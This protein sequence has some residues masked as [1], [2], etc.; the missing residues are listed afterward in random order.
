M[1]DSKEILTEEEIQKR[2][3]RKRHWLSQTNLVLKIPDVIGKEYFHY[4]HEKRLLETDIEIL[5][6]MLNHERSR[7]DSCS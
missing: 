1:E 5:E 2:L 4:L 7:E 3:Q 6:G